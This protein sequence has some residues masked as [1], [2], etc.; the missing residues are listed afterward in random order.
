MSEDRRAKAERIIDAIGLA[1][2]EYIKEAKTDSELTLIVNEAGAEEKGKT[3]P[4]K[5]RKK[6]WYS[7][8]AIAASLLLVVGIGSKTGLFDF[9]KNDVL[10]EEVMEEEK[11]SEST[12][13]A[14]KEPAAEEAEYEAEYEEAF[15]GDAAEADT[16]TTTETPAEVI[17][18]DEP[19]IPQGEAFVLT[20][21]RWKDND[22]WPFFTNLVNSGSIY[23]PS[24]GIDPRNRVQVDVRDEEGNGLRNEAV[25]LYST[26]GELIWTAR[27]DKDGRAYLFVPEGYESSYVMVNGVEYSLIKGDE[28]VAVYDSEDPQGIPTAKP[29]EEI[30]IITTPEGIYQEDLQVMFIIDTTGSMGDELAYLQKDFASIAES[31]G[32]DGVTYSVNFYRDYG[33]KYVTKNNSFTG[34]VN[35]VVELLNDEYAQGGGDTPEAVAEALYETLAINEEWREDC[36]KIA[37]LIFDAPPHYGEEETIKEAVRVAAARGIT[38]V[39]VV[40][41]NAE[42]ETELFG[43]ALAI[44]TN[45][46]YVFLTDHSGVGESH[47]EPII[48]DYDVELL[49]DIIVDLIQEQ[50]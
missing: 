16:E 32:S 49:H 33:D 44:C 35:E 14:A 38:L 21:G 9:A 8:G 24:Y 17:D 10:Y 20:A 29:T 13:A 31:V 25:E 50:R 41:S 42:R 6:L 22:N 15:E 27:T 3:S 11:T 40:A 2:E 47:L 43:R 4:G 23:F 45:G 26:G 5:N 19:H 18:I 1:D 46:T 28:E 48:G 30:E 39:P 12:P 34:D 37:F 7:V 36:K